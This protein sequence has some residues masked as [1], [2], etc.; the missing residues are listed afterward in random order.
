MER[1]GWTFEYKTKGSWIGTSPNGV[2]IVFRRD[3][4]ICDRFTFV[5]LRDPK[6]CGAF[7]NIEADHQIAIVEHVMA[8]IAEDDDTSEE[9]YDGVDTFEYV[10]GM[11]ADGYD[12][13]TSQH[14]G[15]VTH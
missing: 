1:N 13:D 4:G 6:L 7:T 10:N 9:E 15:A 3:V 11:D 5:D 12:T 14:M 8:N 2:P